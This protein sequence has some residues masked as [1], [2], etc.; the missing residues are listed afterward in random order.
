MRP[1]RRVVDPERQ[2]RAVT[3]DIQS[4][5]AEYLEVADSVE[6]WNCNLEELKPV[7]RAL[8]AARRHLIDQMSA[9]ERGFAQD[10]GP[11][12]QATSPRA[13]MPQAAGV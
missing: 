8:A 3:R 7:L 2:G 1:L 10:L 11:E 9:F 6:R 12:A 13:S 4:A 5:M